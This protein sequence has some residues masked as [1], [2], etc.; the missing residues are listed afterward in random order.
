MTVS[1]GKLTS[2]LIALLVITECSW[3]SAVSKRGRA[4]WWVVGGRW[5]GG[6][7]FSAC[8]C[9]F[10][11][12][13]GQVMLCREDQRGGRDCLQTESG[14]NSSKDETSSGPAK[15]AQEPILSTDLTCTGSLVLLCNYY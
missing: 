14:I 15:Q 1:Q 7:V 4:G 12:Q 6:V 3:S 8:V 5:E 9:P 2:L 11:K 10:S 13:P